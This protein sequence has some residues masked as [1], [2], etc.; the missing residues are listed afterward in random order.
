MVDD[1]VGDGDD[2]AGCGVAG[3][4]E[5]RT[6]PEPGTTRLAMASPAEARKGT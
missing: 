4:D 6:L 1:L 2:T 5:E 3:G